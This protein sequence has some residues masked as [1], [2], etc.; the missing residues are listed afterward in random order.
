MANL[1]KPGPTSILHSITLP[2]VS[3]PI[4]ALVDT[5]SSHSHINPSLAKR[6]PRNQLPE[7]VQLFLFDGRRAADITHYVRIPIQSSAS[8]PSIELPLLITIL[9]RNVPVVLGMSFCAL[10]APT[11][12]GTMA[13]SHLTLPSVSAHF[14]LILRLRQSTQALRIQAPLQRNQALLQRIHALSPGRTSL[15]TR[16]SLQHPRNP[17]HAFRMLA[18]SLRIFHTSS[19]LTRIPT[20]SQ[21]HC[22]SFLRHTILTWTCFPKRA[23]IPYRLIV[24]TT[25]V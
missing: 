8:G 12:I 18:Q 11:S 1:N 19:I 23:P 6:F 22:A 10:L 5:G 21:T 14:R 3:A 7:P 25:T 20:I 24:P 17:S 2:R 16:S 13:A 15:S 9:P 4:F